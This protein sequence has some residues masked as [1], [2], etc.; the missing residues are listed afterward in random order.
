MERNINNKDFEQFVKKNADQYRMY[1][2]DKVWKGIYSTLHTRRTWYG[3][4]FVLLILTAAIVTWM[5]VS[6]PASKQQAVNS[7]A[8]NPPNQF[9]LAVKKPATTFL[10]S[11]VKANNILPEPFVAQSG[12]ALKL[13]AEFFEPS[14]NQLPDKDV[15]STQSLV[16]NTKIPVTVNNEKN[17]VEKNETSPNQK[18]FQVNIKDQATDDDYNISS[19]ALS[20]IFEGAKTK[21]VNNTDVYPM[22]IESVLNS[23]KKSSTNSKKHI[24]LQISF[25]PT[26]SYRRL[27][28]NKSFLRNTSIASGTLAYAYLYN[29]NSMVTHKPD[30]GFELG[31]TANYPLTNIFKILAGLQFNINRYGIKAFSYPSEIATIELNTGGFRPD[32]VAKLTNYRNFNGYSSDW[33]QNYYLSVSVPLGAEIKLSKNNKTEFGIAATV[34]PTYILKDRAY[35]ISTDYK[36]YVEVPWLIRRWN[37]NTS[38]ETYMSYSTGKLKWRVGPQVRYQLLS[39]FQNKYPVKENLFDFGLKVGIMLNK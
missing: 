35:L 17:N 10:G 7:L 32:S 15:L 34:Q 13:P 33:L 29:V 39:S 6:A 8:S 23:Y 3:L 18:L 27:T 37:M 9:T 36:N 12:S 26:I 2:S 4:G 24:G 16:A 25:T 1:P 22:T 5:M 14:Q 11:T 30:M 21:S 19:I 28:E 20:R 38:L 31:L